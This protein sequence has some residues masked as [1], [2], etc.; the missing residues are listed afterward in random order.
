MGSRMETRGGNREPVDETDE[1]NEAAGEPNVG[2]GRA[3]G[4]VGGDR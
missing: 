2:D 1:S 3:Y 4:A